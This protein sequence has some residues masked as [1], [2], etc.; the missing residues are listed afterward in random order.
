MQI[1]KTKVNFSKYKGKEVAIVRGEIVASGSSSRVVFEIA[2][3]IFPKV[4]NKDIV[5]LSV[6]K[7]RATIY[8]TPK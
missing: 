1:G 3:K 7:E 5:L 8:I 4:A 6:P 2:K